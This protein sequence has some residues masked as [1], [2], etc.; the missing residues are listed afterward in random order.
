M[1]VLVNGVDDV[2]IFTDVLTS[3]KND[4]TTPYI[5]ENCKYPPNTYFHQKGAPQVN[6][7]GKYSLWVD[8]TPP[9]LSRAKKPSLNRVKSLIIEV[10]YRG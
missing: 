3:A 6:K 10:G 1:T 9:V 7:N 4:V 5:I 2:I 8:V